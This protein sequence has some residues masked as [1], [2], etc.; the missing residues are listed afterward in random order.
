MRG[1]SDAPYVVGCV[2]RHAASGMESSTGSVPCF[3]AQV[4]L[5]ITAGKW[6]L[7]LPRP[8]AVRGVRVSRGDHACC[9]L[10]A[11]SSPARPLCY[12]GR[13]SVCADLDDG[14]WYELR[15]P[16]GT[17]STR[18][19][20]QEQVMPYHSTACR[21][22]R[23]GSALVMAPRPLVR[24]ATISALGLLVVTLAWLASYWHIAV[25]LPGGHCHLYLWQGVLEFGWT[26]HFASSAELPL[27]NTYGGFRY[28]A[29]T[30]VPRYV[31]TPTGW[32]LH[33][34]LWP[35]AIVLAMLPV[36][37]VV[38]AARA[39]HRYVRGHCIECGYDIR[40]ISG[41]CPECASATPSVTGAYCIPL[42]ARFNVGAIAVLVLVMVLVAALA[43]VS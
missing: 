29:I 40:G 8:P 10:L 31:R 3:A 36:A 26:R 28:F 5:A 35:L 12:K 21:R 1:S 24:A 22:G 9:N 15:E 41:R 4:R 18:G 16:E 34:P 39:R 27:T 25:D 42:S 11:D 7:G 2:S 13:A 14:R 32:S 20:V 6:T 23:R 43:A 37:Y 19:A 38:S 17:A 33:V 30:G